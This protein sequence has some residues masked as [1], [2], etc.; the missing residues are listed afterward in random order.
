MNP[1]PTG[2]SLQGEKVSEIHVEVFSLVS[3]G[4]RGKRDKGMKGC[5]PLLAVC[6]SSHVDKDGHLMLP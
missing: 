6:I 1:S 3:A 5:P 4:K 2:R